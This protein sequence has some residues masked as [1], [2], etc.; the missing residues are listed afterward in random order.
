MQESGLQAFKNASWQQF[1]SCHV[2]LLLSQCD[3]DY[4]HSLENTNPLTSLP[5]V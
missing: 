5:F 2:L 4:D 3:T 1:F